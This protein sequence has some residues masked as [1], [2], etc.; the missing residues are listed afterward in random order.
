MH[1][2]VEPQAFILHAI[3]NGFEDR[4]SAVPFVQVK[5]ARA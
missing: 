3:A 2:I 4:K 5:N 1:G